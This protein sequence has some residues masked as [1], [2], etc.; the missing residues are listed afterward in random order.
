MTPEAK[1][2]KLECCFLAS[3]VGTTNSV[4]LSRCRTAFT[5]SCNITV[6]VLLPPHCCP[7]A[8]LCPQSSFVF[9]SCASSCC[10]VCL[11]VS[12]EYFPP[13]F[14]NLEVVLMISNIYFSSA[15]KRHMFFVKQWNLYFFKKAFFYPSL[16][17]V[18]AVQLLS[19][20]LRSE[21]K[22]APSTCVSVSMCVLVSVSNCLHS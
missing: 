3:Q 9:R 13:P 19:V 11:T 18:A 8:S 2:F 1:P 15:F 6:S 12:W 7:F 20:L 21:C 17:V 14:G 4:Y 10:P 22:G 5:L 16:H